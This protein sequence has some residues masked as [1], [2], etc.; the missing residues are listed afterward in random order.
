MEDFELQVQDEPRPAAPPI[1][2]LAGV[3]GALDVDVPV[4]TH[5][6]RGVKVEQ[7]SLLADGGQDEQPA[8]PVWRGMTPEEQREYVLAVAR[9]H[10]ERA[11][12]EQS[13]GERRIDFVRPVRV[14][15]G[16]D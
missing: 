8:G 1:D 3:Q 14:R 6:R 9:A 4:V 2:G 13:Y 7:H 5:T 10:N 16:Q 11:R 15:D 12:E